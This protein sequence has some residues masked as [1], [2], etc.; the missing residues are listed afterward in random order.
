M[1]LIFKK[2]FDEFHNLVIWKSTESEE[3]FKSHLILDQG[4]VD[5]LG[6]MMPHRQQEWLTSRYLTQKYCLST[7]N[8]QVS[9]TS[10]GQP[11]LPD[12]LSH[13]SISHSQDLVAVISNVKP[14]GLDVQYYT[15]KINRVFKKFVNEVEVNTEEENLALMYHFI[16]GAKESM[17]K[18]YGLRKVDFRR[19]MHVTPFEIGCKT[20]VTTGSLI[21]PGGV[22]NFELTGYLFDE[23]ILVYCE[24]SSDFAQDRFLMA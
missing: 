17:Y 11:K 21:H 14:V 3:Y 15:E 13:I 12:S 24:E 5:E 22:L 23:F 8:H 7:D 1:P 10:D 2:D 16:W 9:K 18:A 20:I 6:S 19:D 4:E